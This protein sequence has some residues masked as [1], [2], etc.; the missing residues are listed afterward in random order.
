MNR[1]DIIETFYETIKKSMEWSGVCEG[2]EYARYVDGAVDMTETMID[3]FCNIPW[4]D[5][6]RACSDSACIK[7]Y[8]SDTD[9][10]IA[11]LV[12]EIKA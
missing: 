8:V 5:D 12:S 2:K 1:T 11:A 9:G 3:K 10:E 4:E 7:S 6:I